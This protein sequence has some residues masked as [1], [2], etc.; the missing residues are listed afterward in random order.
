M[1][2]LLPLILLVVILAPSTALADGCP[3]SSCGSTSSAIPGSSIVL[4]RPNGQFGPLQAYDVRTGQRRFALPPGVLSADGRTFVAAVAPKANR[5]TVV[6]Y[7]ARSGKLLRGWSLRARWSAAALSADG[8]HYALAHYWRR[9]IALRIGRSTSALRGTYDVEA[10]SP[11]GRKVFLVHWKRNGYDLQQ[12]DLATNKLTPTRLDE[13]D[14]KM[15]GQATTAVATRDGHWLLTLYSKSDRHSF[16]HALDLRTGLAH[17]IDLPLVGD[18]F[19]IGSTALTLSPDESKLYLASP[20]IGRV[21][22]IDLAT[23]DVTDVRRFR[24]PSTYEVNTIIGPS[25]AV[26]PNGR[27]LAFSAGKL[28]WLYDAAFGVVRKATSVRS[29]VTG[30][31]F[32]PDGRRLLVL[33]RLGEP[34]FLDAA[35]GERR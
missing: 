11:D 10:L 24:G 35:T 8:R 13:P 29:A 5:T 28:V 25:A 7:D 15:T 17:C 16:V 3:P 9:G 27:M 1:R 32:D 18:I 12:L 2:R 31:G 22:T 23:L 33:Q 26:T 14:E 30:L 19:T 6:R 21:A 34:V 20:Y 4:V